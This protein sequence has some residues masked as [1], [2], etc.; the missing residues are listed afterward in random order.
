[1]PISTLTKADFEPKSFEEA[2][3]HFGKKAALTSEAFDRLT[4]EAK[5]H[6][7][8]VAGMHK[9]RL[10]QRARDVVHKAIRDGTPFREVRLKLLALFDTD[11]VP[12]P[13]LSRLRLAFT[14]NGQ[15]AYNDARREALDDPEIAA[16]FPFR[17]YLTVGNGRPGFRGVRPEHAA[18]HGLVFTWDDPFWDAHTPPWGFGCRCFFRPLTRGQVKRMGVKVRNLGYVRKGI[19][20]GGRRKRGMEADPRFA[21]GEFDLTGIDKELRK[22][23]EEMVK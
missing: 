18:L 11:G 10:I 22:A 23:V 14:Q 17:M 7:F 21:R 13:A 12:P 5:A 15:Q 19:R 1:M 4:D 6:A 9:A 2:A 3:E 20:V 16:A 8:K